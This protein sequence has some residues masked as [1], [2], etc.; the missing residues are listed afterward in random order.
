MPPKQSNY[1]SYQSYRPNA[2]LRGSSLRPKPKKIRRFTMKRT[3]LLICLLCIAFV[4]LTAGFLGFTLYQNVSKLTGDK[5]PLALLALFDPGPL[6][7]SNGRTNILVA[8]LPGPNG[9]QPGNNFLTDS[10]MVMSVNNSTKSAVLLSIPRDMWVNIP[11]YGYAKI[12]EAYQDGGMSLLSQVVQNDFG[13]TADYTATVS[14]AAF[15]DGVN[16]VGGVRIDISSP[17]PRGIFDAYTHL[18]LP[19]GWVTLNGQQALDLARARGDEPAGDISY[20]IPDSDFTRTMYQRQIVVAL[21]NK[22]TTGS[23]L[24]NPL[25]V[26]S[27][28]SAVGNNV[29]TNLSLGNLV[30][31]YDEGKQLKNQNIVSASLNDL[32]G[33]N[34]VTNQWVSYSEEALV[35]S[36]GVNDFGPIQ[37][38]I[39]ALLYP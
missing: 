29:T 1:H 15:K 34:Y 7:E 36:A 20:G 33:Q 27:L 16:A 24:F 39:Q 26:A 9:G 35:P 21:K 10:I 5:N 3:L 2:P 31:L 12:N 19:N 37:A 30:K 4:V 11:G 23:V 28:A 6:K 32:G 25:R 17:D 18:N 38:A 14:Y 8:G 22:A 13:I